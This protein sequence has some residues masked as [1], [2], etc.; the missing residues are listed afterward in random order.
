MVPTATAGGA[1]ALERGR[2]MKIDPSIRE[3]PVLL[4]VV[5]DSVM[6]PAKRGQSPL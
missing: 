3:T 4:V 5:D 2:R 1:E 6:R